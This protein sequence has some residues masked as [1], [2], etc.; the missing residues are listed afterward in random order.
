MYTTLRATF[1]PLWSAL[2]RNIAHVWDGFLH[3]NFKLM[4]VKTEK[5]QKDSFCGLDE[6]NNNVV[7]NITIGKGNYF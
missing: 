7:L 6:T 1:L 2:L 4:T 5:N 3:E